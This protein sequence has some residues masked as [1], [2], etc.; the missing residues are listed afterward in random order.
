MRKRVTSLAAASALALTMG[1]AALPAQATHATHGTPGT[2]P[3]SAVLTADGNKF[4]HNS[5]DFDIVTEA[6]LAVLAAKPNSPVGL[7]TK[8]D[9][10]L[11]AFVPND[12]AFRLL[13]K[14]LTGKKYKSE[15]TIFSKVA[16]LGIDTV[17][18]VLLY[19]VVPGR[20]IDSTVAVKANGVRLKTGNGDSLKIQVRR[21]GSLIKI[22]DR[23]YNSRNARV[24][25]VDV[26]KG[27]KQIAHVVDRVIRPLD[28]PPLK[29]H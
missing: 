3:L 27:N 7:L 23:D 1:A 11:T 12:R 16:S 20:T 15:K 13:V 9:V 25:A 10:A 8:G 17:E 24:I 18:S 21:H 22:S 19:H 4:D 26:N 29:K 2:K 6:V 28:L 14:D 5:K